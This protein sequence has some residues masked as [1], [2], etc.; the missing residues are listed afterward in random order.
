MVQQRDYDCM[1]FKTQR[2]AQ[3]IYMKHSTDVYDLD[4]NGDG[5]ACSSLP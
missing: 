3:E 5:I 4:R 1:D 2:E